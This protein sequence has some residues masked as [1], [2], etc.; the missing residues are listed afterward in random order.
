MFLDEAS[1]ALLGESILKYGYPRAWDGNFLITAANGNDFTQ[2]FVFYFYPWIQYYI[3][4]FSQLFGNSNFHLR[5]WYVIIGIVSVIPF[6]C[7]SFDFIKN[8]KTAYLASLFYALS[9]NVLLLIRT[10]R[11][12]APSLLLVILVYLLYEKFIKKSTYKYCIL[13][14]VSCILLFHTFIAF[15]F[16]TM[17]VIIS[18]YILFDRNKKNIKK[19]VISLITITVFTLFY[20]LYYYWL[21]NNVGATR[22]G[23]Q[24]INYFILLVPRYFWLLHEKFFP[25]L[26]LLAIYLFVRAL[27]KLSTRK[28][29]THS[30]DNIYLKTNARNINTNKIHMRTKWLLIAPIVVNILFI[31]MFCNYYGERFLIACIPSTFILSAYIISI[32]MRYDKVIGLFVI[33]TFVFTNILNI[34]PYLCIKYF[35]INPKNAEIIVKSP[36]LNDVLVK[37]Q[38]LD[39]EEKES[40]TNTMEDDLDYYL[41]NSCY[42]TSSIWDYYISMKNDFDDEIEGVIKFLK[43]YAK[44]GDSVVSDVWYSDGIHFYTGLKIIN[45]LY[46]PNRG[47]YYSFKNFNNA[48]KYIHLT[49]A[50][51]KLVNWI[52]FPDDGDN[53]WWKYD[54]N[55]EKIEIHGYSISD[56]SNGELNKKYKPIYIYR[57]KRTTEPLDKTVFTKEDL[58]KVNIID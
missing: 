40:R 29:D 47:E 9:V 16:I 5:F 4:A 56:D 35:D 54:T 51:N 19:F 43:I 53:G 1:T 3:S 22:E 44:E 48:Y 18:C 58:E 49:K 30:Y 55:F 31:P 26:P 7:L 25:V 52:V 34:S 21:L 11:Y 27:T 33:L 32:I 46:L 45:R 6:Y 24:G 17:A 20:F 42:V 39:G 23:F 38:L 14:A 41:N 57:N 37:S 13:F 10:V 36:K 50:D 15:F 12:Y 2:N 8:R 28:T